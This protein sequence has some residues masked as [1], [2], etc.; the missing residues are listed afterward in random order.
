MSVSDLQR[1]IQRA[2]PRIEDVRSPDRTDII[3]RNHGHL[4]LREVVDAVD[5]LEFSATSFTD[6]MQE[7]LQSAGAETEPSAAAEV[8]PANDSRK[9]ALGCES[10]AEKMEEAEK[11]RGAAAFAEKIAKIEKTPARSDADEVVT[12]VHG[13]FRAVDG[14]QFLSPVLSEPSASTQELAAA[15]SEEAPDGEATAEQLETAAAAR[16]R[17]AECFKKKDFVGAV[18]EYTTAIC[19]LPRGHSELHTLYS[20][21]SAASLQQTGD[22]HGIVHAVAALADA[23]RCVELA[24]QWPKGRFR[25]GNCLRQLGFLGDAT[26]AFRAGKA[27]EAENKDWEKEVQKTEQARSTTRPA[28]VR[29]M[30]LAL[31]PEFLSA[32]ARGGDSSGVLQVQANGEFTDFGAPKW[33]L[34]REGKTNAKAQMRYAFLPRKDY[35]ANVAANLQNPP[36]E[37]VAVVDADGQALKIAEIAAFMPEDSTN[38]ATLHI[39]VRNGAS[40]KM[41]AIICRVPC[42][43]VVKTFLGTRKEPDPPKGSVENVLPLQRSSGFPKFLPRYLGFQAFPG[44]D[45]NYPVIDLDRDAP[46][47][48]SA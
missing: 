5:A 26:H 6:L 41:M 12:A 11:A 13:V 1:L 35:L 20:N 27:L 8:V 23:R 34:V 30:I 32:W 29:Q 3:R 45:L 4:T 38:Y 47:A 14:L 22:K 17:G 19:A 21:R 15:G 33:R 37:G 9:E 7:L 43:E 10:S 25:E 39:D 44:G 48:N 36:A 24:P 16:G 28:L 42:D 18:A 2:T 40:N 31:L 46:G